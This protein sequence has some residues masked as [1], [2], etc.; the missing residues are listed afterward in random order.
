MP[1]I[2]LRKSTIFKFI[3]RDEP[4]IE[5]ATEVTE[6]TAMVL[7]PV[8]RLAK[9]GAR[10]TQ[11]QETHDK[12]ALTG[13]R[14]R[15]SNFSDLLIQRL[16][17]YSSRHV[18]NFSHFRLNAT[19]LNNLNLSYVVRFAT[20][21]AYVIQDGFIETGRLTIRTYFKHLSGE[22]ELN[23][24][25]FQSVCDV[26]RSDKIAISNLAFINDVIKRFIEKYPELN[27][28]LLIPLNQSRESKRHSIL[29]EVSIQRAKIK[30]ITLHN[31]QSKWGG[32]VYPNCLNDLHADRVRKRYY[33]KQ[34]DS[35]SCGFF[36]YFY[37]KSILEHRS[38]VHLPEIYVTLK[39]LVSNPSLLKDTL[40]ENFAIT[41]PDA[42]KITE[43][44]VALPWEK[45][46]LEDALDEA[47]FE[48]LKALSLD[49]PEEDD[50][51]EN[52]HESNLNP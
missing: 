42:R 39:A 44:G 28:Q 41:K 33:E 47:N 15:R 38:A 19:Q 25:V 10:K 5:L 22:Q 13:A 52:T 45:K 46:A 27:A 23:F 26:E 49:F 4:E 16:P 51:E 20:E 30:Q 31:S 14:V 17:P 7:L 9:Q 37:I 6:T 40:N 3:H 12:H 48:K 21:N 36:V 35:I 24:F 2:A 29:V 8:S 34:D 50:V 43:L 32:V 18:N 11:N 1:L